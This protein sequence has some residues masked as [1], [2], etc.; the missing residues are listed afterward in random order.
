MKPRRG[1]GAHRLVPLSVDGTKPPLGLR[2]YQVID[3]SRWRGRRNAPEIAAAQRAIQSIVKNG[4]VPP[5]PA[6]YAAR[7]APF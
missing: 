6:A 2:Q 4:Y 5:R 7:A 3:I 1:A